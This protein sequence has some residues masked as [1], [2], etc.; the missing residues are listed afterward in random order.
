M[1]GKQGNL[2]SAASV[3]VN[4]VSAII[5]L[6]DAETITIFGHTSGASTLT[7]MVSADRTN[8]YAMDTIA[9]NGDFA[10]TQYV[11]VRYMQLKSSAAVTITATLMGK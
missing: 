4:G 7:I 8:F 3:G 5:D 11:G 9:A 1:I 10:D 6:L 2:W